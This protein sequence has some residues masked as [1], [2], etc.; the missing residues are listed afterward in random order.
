MRNITNIFH[1][2]NYNLKTLLGFELLFKLSTIIAT[3]VFVQALNMIMGASGY[4][5]LTLENILPFLLEPKTVILLILLI[6]LMTIYTMFE[7]TTILIILDCSFHKRK[8][9]I[10]DAIVTAIYKC[11]NIFKLKNITLPIFVLFLIPLLNI[12]ITSSFISTIKIPEFIMDFIIKNQILL[13]TVTCIFIIITS[14]FLKWFYALH[15]FVIEDK[16]F[17]EAKNKSKHLN[18]NRRLKDLLII[19]TSQLIIALLCIA[20]IIIGVLLIIYLDKIFKNIILIKSATATMIWLFIV[21]SMASMTILSTPISY[22]CISCLYYSH[23]QKN[24]EKILPVTIK[25]VKE[26]G[27][28]KKKITKC[29]IIIIIILF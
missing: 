26:S 6:I 4:H 16:N 7:I 2:I 13:A 19:G 10:S 11:K 23:K 1:L 22:A 5:Y 21:L 8:I 29:S 28:L 25:E 9:K 18:K 24:R 15:Y 17:R 12:G 20:I 27:N 14:I 3:K